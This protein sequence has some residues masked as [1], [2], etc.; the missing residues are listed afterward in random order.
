[1]PTAP[2]GRRSIGLQVLGLCIAIALLPFAVDWRSPLLASYRPAAL[3]ALIAV[4]LLLISIATWTLR[5]SP[6]SSAGSVLGVAVLL[7]AA[8][9]LIAALS[10]EA[11]F[12]RVR[13]HVLAADPAQL[14]RLG[15]HLIVGYRDPDE[16]GQLLERRAIGG[17]F[18]G[19]RNVEGL[20][21]DAVRRQIASW[22]DTRRRQ[23]LPP[24][25]IATDQEGGAISRVSPPLPRQPSMAS[26]VASLVDE[27]AR[28][29]AA[30]AYGLTQGRAL[31]RLGIN[32]NFAPVVDLNKNL[33]NPNDRYTRIRDRAISADPAIVTEVARQYCLGLREAGVR[34]TLKHFPGLGSVY[35]DTHLEA[36][37]LRTPLDEL[38]R[39]DWIPF[40][41]LMG[42]GAF[43][44]L[45]HAR[46]TALD[47]ERPVSFS[48]AVVGDL[49]RQTWHHDGVL[50][51]DDFSMG[52]VYASKQGIAVAAIAALNVGVDLI[53]IA[54]DPAQYF[55]V[56]DALLAG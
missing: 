22:Q 32:L 41:S 14:E 40:R 17:V 6:W 19:A 43:T 7:A 56:M 50:V 28:T 21:A 2:R 9:V 31:V 16:I 49:L 1:M 24:L 27:T 47:P 15:R 55:G 12:H 36:G 5:R 51:T 52:A 8:A 33:V 11:R 53:L 25:L 4:P 34:C 44:M 29:A 18:V 48:H 38:E 37:H 35:E 13:A 45:S 30:H 42:N 26:A 23:G 39:S 10:L 3:F 54:Y 20:S 46:L